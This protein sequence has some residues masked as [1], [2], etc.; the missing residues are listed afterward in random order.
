MTENEMDGWHHR[1]DGHEFEQTL[2]DGEGKEAW[3]P[4]VY[5]FNAITI[6]LLPMT[7]FIELEQKKM[8]F[9]WKNKTGF[10]DCALVKNPPANAGN[11][12][13]VG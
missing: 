12:R 1:L 2:G 3:C 6:K 9:V 10:P 13:E 4:A 8:Q 5:R 11:I 7:F